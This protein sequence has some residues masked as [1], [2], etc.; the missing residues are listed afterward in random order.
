MTIAYIPREIGHKSH[1]S[2]VFNLYLCQIQGHVNFQKMVSENPLFSILISV[3]FG[4]A[5]KLPGRKFPLSSLFYRLI[6]DKVAVSPI[7]VH[8]WA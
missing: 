1:D 6:F 5:H 2:F 7:G 3:R 4:V 8:N